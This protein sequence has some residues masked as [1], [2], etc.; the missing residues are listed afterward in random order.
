M[1]QW[2]LEP[3]VAAVLIVGMLSFTATICST[4]WKIAPQRHIVQTKDGDRC[5]THEQVQAVAEDI[6]E[7]LNRSTSRIMRDC[8]R[9]HHTVLGR[10]NPIHI[11]VGIL[12]KKNPEDLK[13]S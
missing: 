7:E 1:Y 10:L 3:A 8:R 13:D 12:L 11:G 5:A 9:R 6:K 4:I 2:H